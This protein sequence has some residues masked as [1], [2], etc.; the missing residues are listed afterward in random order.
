MGFHDALMDRL[1]PALDGKELPP[2]GEAL[3]FNQGG[4][5][6]FRA[7]AWG[8]EY[9]RTGSEESR[10][11]L[12]KDF[13]KEQ[14]ED[15][16]M[17]L[18]EAVE[19]FCADPHMNFWICSV[20]A[21]RQGAKKHGHQ[22]V[23]DETGRW[24]RSLSTLVRRGMRPD[25][26]CVLPAARTKSAVPGQMVASMLVK[27]ALTGKRIGPAKR[28]E[29]LEARDFTAVRV[30]IRMIEAG[31]DLELASGPVEVKLRFPITVNK[32]AGGHEAFIADWS[33]PP[34]PSALPQQF[35][36]FVRTEYEQDREEIEVRF[37]GQ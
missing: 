1:E 21:M 26:W 28:P 15:G 33:R 12:L 37:N 34:V 19:Q 20:L 35:A 29:K 11:R 13:F 27:F 24:F 14:W 30:G 31:D 2:P 32:F 5:A 10:R 25:G 6:N 17:C 36:T 7:M 18:G 8:T 9:L 4:T 3:L 22:D 23:L 16:F